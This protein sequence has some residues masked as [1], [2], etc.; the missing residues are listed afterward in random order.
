[1]THLRDALA[2]G[3]FA[4]PTFLRGASRVLDMGATIDSYNESKSAAEADSDALSADWR[5]VG[6]EITFA[7]GKYADGK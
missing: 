3:L 7:I 5:E 1:M 2:F 4:L 6:R